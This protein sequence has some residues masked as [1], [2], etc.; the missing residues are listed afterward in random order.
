MW[1]FRFLEIKFIS[2][3]DMVKSESEFQ[4]FKITMPI[5]LLNNQ[6]QPM[7]E[8]VAWFATDL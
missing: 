7:A 1:I 6:R 4:T 2:C 8:L 5:A 3:S